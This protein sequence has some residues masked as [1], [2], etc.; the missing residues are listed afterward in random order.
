[1]SRKISG[2]LLLRWAILTALHLGHQFVFRKLL[3]EAREANQKQLVITFDP[4]SQDDSSS[5][6]QAFLSDYDDK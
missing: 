1:V 2:D 3:A 4:H 6:Y 5:R